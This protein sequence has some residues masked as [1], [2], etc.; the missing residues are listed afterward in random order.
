MQKLRTP[1]RGRAE[2]RGA[3]ARPTVLVTGASG[4]IGRAL[5]LAFGAEGWRVG[6]HYRMR[7]RDAARTAALVRGRGGAA[8]CLQADIR[9]DK[10]TQEMVNRVIDR[11]GRLDVMVCNAGAASSEFVLRMKA[12]TWAA[13]VETNL[14]GTFHCLQAAGE[15]MAGQCDGAVIVIGSLAGLQGSVGQ[16]AYAASK[17]GLA[18]LI[19]TAAKE[20]GERNIRV[21]MVLPGWHKTRLSGRAF[22]NDVPPDHILGRTPSLESVARIIYQLALLRDSSGQ[23]WNLDSRVL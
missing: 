16:A 19:K 5:C 11:W 1:Q 9:D 8:L 4:G 6:V 10:Q 7:A 23:V 18:G 22:P 3:G 20:W 15:V 2:R 17:A 21:N 13:A 12:D 14:T